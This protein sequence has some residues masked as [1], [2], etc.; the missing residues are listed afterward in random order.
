MRYAQERSTF[1]RFKHAFDRSGAWCSSNVDMTVNQSGHDV[2]ALEVYDIRE[3]LA[4][5]SSRIDGYNS[6][7]AMWIVALGIMAPVTVSMM[8]AFVKVRTGGGEGSQGLMKRSIVVGYV[9]LLGDRVA[10]FP[11][12]WTST[13]PKSLKLRTGI[14]QITSLRHLLAARTAEDPEV[15]ERRERTGIGNR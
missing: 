1:V 5:R 15:D 12:R 8:L 9:S 11:L 10:R 2:L 13:A 3:Q 4:R 14:I 7:P 6:P